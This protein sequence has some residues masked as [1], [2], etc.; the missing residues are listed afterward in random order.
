MDE[1]HDLTRGSILGKLT[2]FFFP[3][4]FGMLFFQLYNTVDAIVVGRCL[5]PAALAAESERMS[6]GVFTTRRDQAA[7]SHPSP[8]SSRPA[9][10]QKHKMVC[11]ARDSALSSC[12]P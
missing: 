1:M 9:N 7:D 4:L 10:M 3:I 12:A 6:A 8:D 11:T 2:R 5:G